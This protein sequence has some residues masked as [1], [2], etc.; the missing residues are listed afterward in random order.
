MLKI[1]QAR[2]QQYLNHE[3]L[4]V[5]VGFRKGRGTREQ[6]ANIC[7]IIRKAREFQKNISFSF[8]V[9]AKAFDLWITINCGK[10]W[11]R[12]EDHTTQPASWETCMQD[13]WW[14]LT[15]AGSSSKAHTPAAALFSAEARGWGWP[16]ASVASLAVPSI[17]NNFLLLHLHLPLSF[18]FYPKCHLL[19][20]LCR[21]SQFDER[22][23]ATNAAFWTIRTMVGKTLHIKTHGLL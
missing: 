19:H 1:L 6:I 17:D 23:S 22:P 4:D 10:F 5:Q 21:P 9:Y 3:L 7:W 13:V 20:G 18:E 11:K 8:T 2:L 16:G 12:W 14:P 15:H